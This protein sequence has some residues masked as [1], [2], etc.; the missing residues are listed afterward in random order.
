MPQE[1][2]TKWERVWG[3]LTGEYMPDRVP[4]S[5]MIM[6]GAAA[7]LQGLS[8]GAVYS[9]YYT[10]LDALIKTHKDFGGWDQVMGAVYTREL[11]YANG[12]PFRMKLPGV[13]VP[14]D[15]VLQYD[16]RK[17]MEAEDYNKILEMGYYNWYYTYKFPD[18]TGF[19]ITEVAEKYKYWTD[20][21]TTM[22][23]RIITE[24]ETPIA[25]GSFT[26]HPF[27]LLSVARTLL[28]F[29]QD[30]YFKA[31]LVE[32]VIAKMT[33]EMIPKLIDANKASG[34]MVCEIIEERASAYNYPLEIS[35]RFF[36]PYLQK[37]VEALHAEGIVTLLHLDQPWTK[38]IPQF[39]KWLPKN[40]FALAFDGTTDI[41]AAKQYL[42]DYCNLQG[43]VPGSLMSLGTP[44]EVTAYC[45]RLIKEVGYDGR[46]IL[47]NGCECPS[48]VKADNLRAMLNVARNA[49]Y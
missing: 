48:D 39:K 40:S 28:D 15:Y 49:F 22:Y 42:G 20:F 7:G 36:F 44:E 38:N 31:D 37:I 47:V 46:F 21:N 41:I 11:G 8:Q 18:L 27:F 3:A 1:T 35:D 26:I 10:A 19:P 9:N 29:S 6:S 2:M 30:L 14:D 25:F 16:E 45:K 32:K 33:D 13:D 4:V 34:I 24:L 12:A 43:D 17:E 5:P 23:T